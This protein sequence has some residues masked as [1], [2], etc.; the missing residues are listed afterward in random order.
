M[1][2]EFKLFKF[3]GLEVSA[4]VSA[5]AGSLLLWLALATVGLWLLEAPLGAAIL[6]GLIAVLLHWLSDL[7]HHWGHARAARS[8]GYPMTGVRLW[9]VLGTS[10]YPPDEPELPA[11]VHRRR[12]LG[13]PL[14]SFVLSLVAG[15]LA[16]ALYPLGGLLWWLAAFLF[17]DN[18]L[19]FTLGALTP[20]GFTDGS[21]L[22]TWRE[23]G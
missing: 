13:G 2:Q 15:V 11:A 7:I 3:A 16:F 22:L 14:A 1:K 23:R 18:L 12:A 5:L 17:L 21:T 8:T 9:L 19:F 20:L 6:G 4:T 10:L